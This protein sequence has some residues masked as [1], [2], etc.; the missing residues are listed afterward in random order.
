MFS[1]QPERPKNA[2]EVGP[3]ADQF[4]SLPV[5]TP[6]AELPIDFFGFRKASQQGPAVDMVENARNQHVDGHCS[7]R[8]T[9][10]PTPAAFDSEE[11][12]RALKRWLTIATAL[13]DSGVMA[14]VSDLEGYLYDVLTPK[15]TGTLLTRASSWS[16]F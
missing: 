5:M 12:Q 15:S 1:Y 7:L 11:R 13:R 4:P 2:W 9:S 14:N 6:R 16:V 8:R 10:G 3:L